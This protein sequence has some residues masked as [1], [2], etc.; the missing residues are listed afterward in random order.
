MK[1]APAPNLTQVTIVVRSTAALLALGAL[2]VATPWLRSASSAAFLTYQ[3]LG[4]LLSAV[5][6]S[7]TFEQH[8]S[9]Y[10]HNVTG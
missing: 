2:A 6:F 5:A 8:F 1:E 3:S 10:W 9:D 4:V 7:L